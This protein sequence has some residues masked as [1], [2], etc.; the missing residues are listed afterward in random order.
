MKV[1]VGIDWGGGAHAVCVIDAK[2]RRLDRFEVGHDREG[3][4]ALIAQLG[5]YG[6]A[7]TMQ[8]ERNRCRGMRC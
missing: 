4:L 8:I 6:P 2:S 3:L 7:C 1:S 5:K